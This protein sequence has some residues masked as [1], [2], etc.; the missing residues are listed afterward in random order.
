M[1]LAA[2]W[3]VAWATMKKEPYIKYT[4]EW[5]KYIPAT[6]MDSPISVIPPR[7]TACEQPRLEQNSHNG[8]DGCVAE[9]WRNTWVRILGTRGWACS[10]TQQKQEDA[11]KLKNSLEQQCLHIDDSRYEP[12]SGP[13][14]KPAEWNHGVPGAGRKRTSL[15]IAESSLWNMRSLLSR[16]QKQGRFK[17][18]PL[19]VLKRWKAHDTFRPK[20]GTC[21]LPSW[22]LRQFNS[23]SFPPG[24]GFGPPPTQ[25]PLSLCLI[26]SQ[27]DCPAYFLHCPAWWAGHPPPCPPC[28]GQSHHHASI[29][30]ISTRRTALH[31]RTISAIPP[32]RI[33]HFLLRKA[34]P[35]CLSLH[36][37]CPLWVVL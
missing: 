26:V 17:N 29:H 25:W 9:A 11:H 16:L 35:K 7:R 2:T 20:A 12:I 6:L 33:K 13:L 10:Q 30:A 37:L 3:R 27:P 15:N 36:H 5:E 34:F 14:P 19:P 8:A 24:P 23:I 1:T 4:K 21:E 28:L 31:F 22:C 18:R 32:N